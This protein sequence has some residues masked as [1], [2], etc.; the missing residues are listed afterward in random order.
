MCLGLVWN[1]HYPDR[2]PHAADPC[3]SFWWRDVLQLSPIY[4]AVTLVSVGDGS[5][6]LFWKDDWLDGVMEDRF[7]TIFSFAKNLDVS[8]QGLLG[9]VLLCQ[10]QYMLDM[11]WNCCKD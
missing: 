10:S 4:R 2:I 5:S 3:G 9:L 8:V 1:S 6:T 11:N 7:Q